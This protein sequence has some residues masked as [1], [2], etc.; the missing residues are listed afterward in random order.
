[1]FYQKENDACFR[2][3]DVLKG[4]PLIYPELTTP[5]YDIKENA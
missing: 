3:G 5:V 4:F 2:F 1:M